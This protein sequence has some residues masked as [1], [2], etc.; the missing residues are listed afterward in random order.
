M[1]EFGADVAIIGGGPTCCS[2]AL[3][4]RAKGYSV[5]VIDDLCAKE[6]PTE[7]SSPALKQILSSLGAG[8]AMTACEP[9]HG[10]VSNWGRNAP[11]LKPG[12]TS[13]FGNAWFIHRHR[14]DS[15]LQQLTRDMGVSWLETKAEKMS[16]AADG[17]EV[18]ANSSKISARR[19]IIA[20]GSPTWT[21]EFTGQKLNNVDSLVAFWA[22]LPVKLLERLLRIETAELGWWYSCPGEKDDAFVCCVTDATEARSTQIAD[23]VRWNAEFQKTLIFQQSFGTATANSV[24]IISASTTLL[25]LKHGRFWVAAG[26]SALKL[27][28]LGSS[29]VITALESGRRAASA[30][31]AAMHG[32]YGNLEKYARWSSQLS[33]DFS[34]QRR[35]QYKLEAQNRSHG[36]WNR[37]K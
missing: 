24:N 14:F 19:M 20:T 1:K 21:A 25:P 26:D 4:L 29:G 35:L 27:D 32:E 34:R 12:M 5:V 23:I 18:I 22:K 11:V 31:M 13:P 33:E 17:V 30:I 9:C 2:A 28:P 16:F 36:F 15:C 6:K 8:S 7:T 37:R 10:I 3:T